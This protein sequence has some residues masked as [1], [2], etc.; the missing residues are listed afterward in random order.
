M[1]N[2]DGSGILLLILLVIFWILLVP[3]LVMITW[4]WLMP[5][6]IASVGLLTWWKAFFLCLMVRLINGIDFN[7][8]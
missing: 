7:K 8:S 5:Q 3:Y 1:S 6:L 2:N 4:N